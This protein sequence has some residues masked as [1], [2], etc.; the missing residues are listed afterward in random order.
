MYLYTN[1]NYVSIYLYVYRETEFR[2]IQALSASERKNL[3]ALQPFFRPAS[4][5]CEWQ[6]RGSFQKGLTSG[7]D[8]L[9]AVSELHRRKC[10]RENKN[11]EIA[12]SFSGNTEVEKENSGQ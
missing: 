4:P 5:S 2:S 1:T 10:E 6:E 7:A 12:R 11:Q 3:S 9:D 8:H